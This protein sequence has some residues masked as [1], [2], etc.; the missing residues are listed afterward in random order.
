MRKTFNFDPEWRFHLGDIQGTKKNSHTDAYYVTKAGRQYNPASKDW[1]DGGWQTVDLPHDYIVGMPFSPDTDISHGYHVK[2]NSWYRKVFLLPRELAGKHVLLSFEGI[3]VASR[4]Y[5]NGSLMTAH[6]SGY[7]EANIDITDRA[8]F[9]DAP[10]TVAVYVDGNTTEG[11]WYEGAGIYRHVRLYVKELVHI[12]HNGV[13]VLPEFCE[14]SKDD[15]TTKVSVL[16]ENSS[17]DEAVTVRPRVKL[18]FEGDEVAEMIGEPITVPPSD[19]AEATVSFPAMAVERWDVDSPRLYR[20][21]VTLLRDFEPIDTEEVTFGYRTVEV[22]R[23]EGFILNG[24]PLKLRGVCNHQDHA[25]VGVAVPDSIQDYRVRLLKEMGVN[26]YRCAHN[27]PA[28]EILDAC[29]RYGILVMDEHRRFE[30]TPE[31]LFYLETLV[32]RD[33][34]HPSVVFWSLF[35]E[36]PLQNTPEGAAIFRRQKATVEKLDTSRPILGAMNGNAE[37]AGQYMSVTGINYGIARRVADDGYQKYPHLSFV[38]SENCSTL[39]TRGCTET[40]PRGKIKNSSFC[41]GYE[42]DPQV[43]SDYDEE[44]PSWGD[45]VRATWGYSI[46]RPWHAGIFIWTGFD[47]RGEPTP[48]CWPSVSS[49]FGLMDTCGNPKAAYYY[50][51][52]CFTDR[53]MVHINPHWNFAEGETVRVAVISNCEEVELFLNG[54]SL[55][56]RPSVV[57]EQNEWQVPFEAGV[58]SAVAYRSG[59]IVARTERK[60]AGKAVAV[61]LSADRPWLMADGHDAVPVNVSLVDA[62][63]NTLPTATSHVAFTVEGGKVL[64]TGNGDPNSHENDTLPERDLFAGLAQVIV[65][66]ATEPGTPL[67]LTATVEGLPPVTLTL[68]TLEGSGMPALGYCSFRVLSG[69]TASAVTE[70]RPD[71]TCALSDNDMNTL[72]PI[73]LGESFDPGFTVGWRFLRA[74]LPLKANGETAECLL[75]IDKTH[76]KELAVAVN[77][78]EVFCGEDIYGQR[79]ISFKVPAADDYDL[80]ILVRAWGGKPSGLAGTI[81]ILVI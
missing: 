16:C 34:N 27:P 17:Y 25:G 31:Q 39:A 53:P 67:S 70:E 28:K 55:G 76:V 63:G 13:F 29:D 74:K 22:R 12:A 11:W 51:K 75:E 8:Y 9:G 3:S 62:D 24:R 73:A 37:G 18:F 33:R 46:A 78:Q 60:T 65:G 69:L 26:A 32:R 59:E 72:S 43:M 58:I 5:F 30:S 41:P 48:F 79:R 47:Y 21:E 19:R 40:S 36:E 57:S 77:G 44:F 20:A 35:N 71:Y 54:R 14:G 61:R 6:N 81:K 2:E 10:N 66:R 49:Q 4:I 80:R 45:S 7:I 64:G 23:E 38:G 50:T 68:N 52:A 1:D 42:N 56:R 15:F